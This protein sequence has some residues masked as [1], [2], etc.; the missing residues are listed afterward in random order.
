[1]NNGV[2]EQEGANLKRQ[3]KSLT[4]EEEKVM[5]QG[6]KVMPREESFTFDCKAYL[7]LKMPKWYNIFGLSWERYEL[8][9]CDYHFHKGMNR[10]GEVCTGLKGGMLTASVIGTPSQM[11]LAWMFDHTKKFNGEVTVMDS[12][13]ETIEQVFF[14]Q[15]RLTGLNLNYKAANEPNTVTTLTMVVD[16]LQIGNAY[17]ENLNQ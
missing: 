15:A 12:Y 7:K 2:L 11:L 4:S 5:P 1:M 14:E 6:E 13:D 10:N 8:V 16:N 17:F 9:D 3:V